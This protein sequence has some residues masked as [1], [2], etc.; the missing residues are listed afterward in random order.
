MP[1]T[2]VGQAQVI[3]RTVGQGGIAAAGSARAGVLLHRWSLG[4]S[5]GIL[6]LNHSH[7]CPQPGKIFSHRHLKQGCLEPSTRRA[8]GTST[9]HDAS[10]REP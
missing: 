2:S 7:Q 8:Y 10:Q 3:L 5:Q 1:T 9:A 6:E 4:Q